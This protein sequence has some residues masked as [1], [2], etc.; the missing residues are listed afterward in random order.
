MKIHVLCF[1]VLI[2]VLLLTYLLIYSSFSLI[3]S[4]NFIYVTYKLHPWCK[5]LEERLGSAK[6]VA[7][8]QQ[9]FHISFIKEALYR[10]EARD[11]PKWSSNIFSGLWQSTIPKK[12]KLFLWTIYTKLS[13]N[14]MEVFHKRLPNISPDPNWCTI[15]KENGEK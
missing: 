6:M 5:H 2:I 15:F 4:I 10:L 14:T 3:N 13:L 8:S 9:K 12:C 11:I 1:L 7:Q